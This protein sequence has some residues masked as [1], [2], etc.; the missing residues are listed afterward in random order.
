M[1][2]I[3]AH[4]IGLHYQYLAPAC[5]YRFPNYQTDHQLT[6]SYPPTYKKR[7]FS[8]HDVG[9][10]AAAALVGTAGYNKQI[11][12]LSGEGLTFDEVA[13][14][15]SR[16]SGMQIKARFRTEEETRELLQS[17]KLPTLQSDLYAREGSYREYDPKDLER[18]GITLESLEE[19]LVKERV[20]LLETLGVKE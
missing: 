5:T 1:S 15:L 4:T 19:F 10:F 13:T 14:I 9:K 11:I 17:G 3:Q 8:P 20:K 2:L 18:F 6:T 7:H 12:E 16:V